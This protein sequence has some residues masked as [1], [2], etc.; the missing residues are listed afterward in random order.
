MQ[1]KNKL[2][3]WKELFEELD[4][5]DDGAVYLKQVVVT[6]K[7]LNQDIDA[8]L[9]VTMEILQGLRVAQAA[10][11]ERWPLKAEKNVQ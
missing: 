7:A 1:Y 8:N 11:T 10:V 2:I 5:E 6:L 9:Q 3:K 4:P